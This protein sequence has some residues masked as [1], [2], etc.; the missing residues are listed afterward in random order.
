MNY[1]NINIK[2][3]LRELKLKFPELPDEKIKRM[4]FSYG[5]SSEVSK[6]LV[7]NT[8]ISNIFETLI[9]KY[10]PKIVSR[11]IIILI[12]ELNYRSIDILDNHINLLSDILYL[13]SKNNL[14]YK[15]AIDLLRCHLDKGININEQYEKKV[16]N[17]SV[18]DIEKEVENALDKFNNIVIEY[19]SGNHKSLNFLVGYILKKTSGKINA[20]DIREILI[21]K[22][23]NS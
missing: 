21:N 5:L 4:T 15:E 10:H 22:I 11:W 8:I 17:K 6:V 3:M 9:Q 16:I 23:N 13:V 7:S 12:G 2:D 18:V 14:G 20:I 19:K 1:I